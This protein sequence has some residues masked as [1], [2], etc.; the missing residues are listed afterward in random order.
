MESKEGHS[1][2]ESSVQKLLVTQGRFVNYVKQCTVSKC[3]HF[4]DGK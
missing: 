2:C 1:L 4:L 3:A